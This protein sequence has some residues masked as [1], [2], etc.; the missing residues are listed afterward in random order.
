M[1][2]LDSVDMEIEYHNA[3][4]FSI[5]MWYSRSE[6]SWVVRIKDEEGNQIGDAV[7]VY[8]KPEALNQVEY[9]NDKY[10]IPLIRT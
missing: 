6:R 9:W 1:K 2:Y 10:R 7:Y 4:P 3:K 8:S 5:D